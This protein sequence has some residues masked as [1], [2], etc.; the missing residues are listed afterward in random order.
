LVIKSNKKDKNKLKIKKYPDYEIIYTSESE[1]EL[2]Y[3]EDSN[4]N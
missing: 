3:R 1:A 4:L 2:S